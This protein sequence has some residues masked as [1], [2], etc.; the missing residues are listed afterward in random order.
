MRRIPLLATVLALAACGSTSTHATR[1]AP[2]TAAAS[3]SLIHCL[4]A[5]HIDAER[6]TAGDEAYAAA[7]NAGADLIAISSEDG[8]FTYGD[9]W[10]FGSSTAANSGKSAAQAQEHADPLSGY[11]RI[12]VMGPVVGGLTRAGSAAAGTIGACASA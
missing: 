8:E 1:P 6:K 3:A 10:L 7:H 2:P 4:T 5:K 11:A 9:L 12:V